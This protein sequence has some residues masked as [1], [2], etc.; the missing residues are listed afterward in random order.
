MCVVKIH[1]GNTI[2]Y[3]QGKK[4]F[5]HNLHDSHAIEI[6]FGNEN[7]TGT[8]PITEY[9]ASETGECGIFQLFG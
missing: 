6:K 4:T 2:T 5:A 8:I 3:L 7:L 1:A 9:D